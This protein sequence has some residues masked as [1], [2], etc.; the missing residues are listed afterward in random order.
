M[1][2]FCYSN[3]LHQW[4]KVDGKSS[5]NSFA[6]K[7]CRISSSRRTENRRKIP[8]NSEF[9]VFIVENR[10][11]YSIPVA[12]KFSV[13]LTSESVTSV[14]VGG[15]FR[16]FF[17]QCRAS[18]FSCSISFWRDVMSIFS[19]LLKTLRQLLYVVSLKSKIQGVCSIYWFGKFCYEA[20]YTV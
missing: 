5:E 14:Q 9:S 12:K 19:F 6:L 10:R 4:W 3:I 8:P 15:V 11:I 16:Q 13:T 18:N 2:E 17:F 20:V 1:G 7:M